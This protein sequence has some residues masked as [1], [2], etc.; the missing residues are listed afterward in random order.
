MENLEQNDTPQYLPQN[1]MDET[2]PH[3]AQEKSPWKVLGTLAMLALGGIVVANILIMGIGS[4]LGYNLTKITDILGGNA[5]AAD[6][7]YLR[8]SL[9]TQHIFL[10]FIPAALTL[11]IC[12]KKKAYTAAALDKHPLSISIGLGLLWLI[13]SAAF[14]GY[15]QELNKAIPLP[16]WMIASE[17]NVKGTLEAIFS[18]R[19]FTGAIVNTLLIGVMPAISEELLFRGVI[20]RQLGRIFHNDHAQVWITA[21]FFSAIHFQ[22]QGFLPRMILGALLG[23][24]LV[25]SRSLWVPVIVHAFNNGMQVLGLYAMDIKPNEIEKMGES[26]NMH[27]TMAG[28]SLMIMI[29]VGKYFNERHVREFAPKAN[30]SGLSN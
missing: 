19:G 16:K 6:A 11:W 4:A 5:T 25:W 7:T 30:D 23:Y 1:A 20:Q 12:Y 2:L 21:A 9:L 22:F 29:I 14:I 17:E 18:L 26:Q 8:L 24:M 3:V 28:A 13:V 27:W 10:F 15:T